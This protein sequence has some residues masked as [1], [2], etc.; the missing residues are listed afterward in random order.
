MNWIFLSLVFIISIPFG[1]I[2]VIAAVLRVYVVNIYDKQAEK[3][4]LPRFRKMKRPITINEAIL[5]VTK[6]FEAAKPPVRKVPEE[7]NTH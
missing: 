4:N 1:V 7:I 5:P 3:R 2:Y 6:S